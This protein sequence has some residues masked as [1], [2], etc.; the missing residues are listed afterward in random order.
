MV[1]QTKLRWYTCS[2]E[3]HMQPRLHSG[4]LDFCLVLPV[5]L[6]TTAWTHSDFR[7]RP[8][9]LS[10]TTHTPTPT[11]TTPAP[12][13]SLIQHLHSRRRS[14]SRDHLP[15]T[16]P[17]NPNLST[18][19]RQPLANITPANAGQRGQLHRALWTASTTSTADHFPVGPTAHPP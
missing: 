17:T 6:V 4:N 10:A 13:T 16:T 2:S 9:Q 8:H 3:Q 1:N 11:D 15:L 5:H 7:T 18:Q 14:R 12:P 19:L